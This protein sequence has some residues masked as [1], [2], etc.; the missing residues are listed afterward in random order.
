MSNHYLRDDQGRCHTI[1][2]IANIYS[3]GGFLFEMHFFCGPQKL[4]KNG[5]PASRMGRKFFKAFSEWNK[6]TKKQQEKTR[7]SG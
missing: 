3:Y 5:E 6:L 7:I 2:T 4:N 1:L